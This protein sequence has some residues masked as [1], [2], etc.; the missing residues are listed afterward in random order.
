MRERK[1]WDGCSYRKTTP[2]LQVYPQKLH[3]KKKKKKRKRVFLYD[4]F[5]REE[6]KEFF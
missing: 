2:F 6:G 4:G 1:K 3:V 5:P